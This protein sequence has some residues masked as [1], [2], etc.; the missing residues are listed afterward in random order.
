MA[1]CM[2]DGMVRAQIV[3]PPVRPAES[4]LSQPA[5]ALAPRW[6]VWIHN[7]EVTPFE[8]VLRILVRLF[9]LS[10]E[11]A[12]HVALTAHQEGQAVVVVRPREEA[13]RLVKVATARAQLDGYPLRFSAEPEA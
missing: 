4:M 10:E 12:E 13:L 6:N 1:T 9:L 3:E 8:Y 5:K 2:N 11:L 7:D